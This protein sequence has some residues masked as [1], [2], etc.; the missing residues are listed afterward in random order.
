[1]KPAMQKSLKINVALFVNELLTEG[2][3]SGARW[4]MR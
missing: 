4:R 3:K 2:G 1:V